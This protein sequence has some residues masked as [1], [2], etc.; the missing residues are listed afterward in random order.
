MQVV[1]LLSSQIQA[2]SWNA[3]QM[4]G[5]MVMRLEG[6]IRAFGI[7]LPLVVRSC[8][9]TR[10]ETIGGAQRLVVLREMGVD[11]VP[12]VLVEDDD[13]EARLLSQALNRIQGQDD[14]GLRADLLRYVLETLP[15][16]DVLKVL[17]ET[18]ESLQAL[19]DM[20]KESM[21]EHLQAWQTAQAAR[22]KHLQFQLLPSQLEVVDEAL[23]RVMPEA[24][25]SRGDSP[26]LRGTAL[27]LLCKRLLEL[28]EVTP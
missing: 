16:V 4:D 8:G 28:A 12:C 11:S 17:P 10:Y 14:L 23:A 26:N 15:M 22:L 19:V 25:A 20:G 3:N 2:P 7:V 5:A 1:E 9:G 13:A 24:K 27:Y 6:S 18:K 21:A